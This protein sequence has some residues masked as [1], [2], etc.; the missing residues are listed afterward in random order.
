MRLMSIG[1]PPIQL[2]QVTRRRFLL[3][4]AGIGAML[5]APVLLSSAMGAARRSADENGEPE[6]AARAL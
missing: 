4:G 5:Q 3:D 2:R 6:R 1:T